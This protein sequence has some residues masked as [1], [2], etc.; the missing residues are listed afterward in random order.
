M[1]KLAMILLVSLTAVK[2]EAIL[3]PLYQTASEIK[4]IMTDKELGERLQSG[5]AIMKIEKNELGYEVITNRH[6]VQ[7][8]VEYESALRPGPA[9]FKLHFGEPIP[10]SND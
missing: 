4:S 1:K 10:L 2:A 5:E 6:H 7:V 9:H 8:Y 3:P